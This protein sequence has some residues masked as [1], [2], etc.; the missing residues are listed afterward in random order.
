METVRAGR[1]GDALS[2][3]NRCLFRMIVS[4]SDLLLA[5]PWGA[6]QGAERETWVREKSENADWRERA[7]GLTWITESTGERNR[8]GMDTARGNMSPQLP[9][10]GLSLR[11]APCPPSAH[12]AHW[13]NSQQIHR[14]TPTSILS[15]SGAVLKN[16]KTPSL[17]A[18]LE[19]DNR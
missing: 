15:L 19:M 7:T 11:L 14:A 10:A 12:S 1:R 17:L 5:H 6:A 9:P 16:Y 13:H 3:K 4:E 18:Q 8:E 2:H